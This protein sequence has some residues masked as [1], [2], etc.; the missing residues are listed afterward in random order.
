MVIIS[1][2]LSLSMSLGKAVFTS[3]R[4]LA[5]QF[6]L[7][8][9]LEKTVYGGPAFRETEPGQRKKQPFRG[10]RWVEGLREGSA[11]QSTVIEQPKLFPALRSYRIGWTGVHLRLIFLVCL[12]LGLYLPFRRERKTLDP[13]T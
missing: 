6:L 8:C 9:T 7:S 4:A 5:R 3:S 12:A 10:E 2:A 13:W 11:P 1:M